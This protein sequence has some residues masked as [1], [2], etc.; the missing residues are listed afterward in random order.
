MP[1][2]ATDCSNKSAARVVISARPYTVFMYQQH[3][4]MGYPNLREMTHVPVPKCGKPDSKSDGSAA[5]ANRRRRMHS[6]RKRARLMSSGGCWS[7]HQPATARAMPILPVEQRAPAHPARLAARMSE[8]LQLPSNF[9]DKTADKI[10]RSAPSSGSWGPATAAGKGTKPGSSTPHNRTRIVPRIAPG[11]GWAQLKG[12][13]KGLLR[14]GATCYRPARQTTR[15]C[16]AT[17]CGA[18]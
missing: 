1:L 15:L 4:A 2:R 14:R 7:H 3:V 10:T 8:P 18:F 13:P 11:R 12:A 9:V 16:K 17:N 5:S 6:V